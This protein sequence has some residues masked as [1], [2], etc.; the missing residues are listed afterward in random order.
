MHENIVKSHFRL[1][2]TKVA[3]KG[4]GRPKEKNYK[5][6]EYEELK[7]DITRKLNLI[8]KFNDVR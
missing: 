5:E 1:K 4:K 6:V 7:A 8:I 2:S 3:K